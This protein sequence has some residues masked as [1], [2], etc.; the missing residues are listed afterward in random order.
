M[1]IHPSRRLRAGLAGLAALIAG[2]AIAPAVFA[3]TGAPRTDAVISI[4]SD[5]TSPDNPADG[6]IPTFDLASYRLNVSQNGADATADV[7]ST[8]TLV[9]G[10]FIDSSP[11]EAGI[12]P[13]KVCGTGSSISADSKTLVCNLGKLTQGTSVAIDYSVQASGEV[14]NGD[15]LTGT[16]STP[17]APTLQQPP[18]TITGTSQVDVAKTFVSAT[19]GETAAGTPGK[20]YRYRLDVRTTDASGKGGLPLDSVSFTD[21]WSDL[22]AQLPG[23]VLV[24]Q[25][26][27]YNPSVSTRRAP[28]GPS[29]TMTPPPG[30]TRP[31]GSS[32][33]PAPGR[34]P[35][36]TTLTP[37]SA[38]P[39]PG[40]RTSRSPHASRRPRSSPRA[41]SR[42][43]SPRAPL[44][45]APRT[46]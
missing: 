18:L 36:P 5:S 42:S 19:N 25:S 13:P 43:S 34:R 40:S 4:L 7:V 41:S 39:S 44:R 6:Q 9:N 37:A 11:T 28:C 10:K 21:D 33:T 1:S 27:P 24:T 35:T 20:F 45:S 2:S 46:S 31:S 26:D 16:I 32:R 14:A 15:E 17:G 23:A 30:R 22:K 8:V 29:P 3:E 12:N 38:S